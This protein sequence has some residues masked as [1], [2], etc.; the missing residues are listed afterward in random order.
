MSTAL[1]RLQPKYRPVSGEL[2][3]FRLQAAIPNNAARR[4][5]MTANGP[6]A[7]S[8]EAPAFRKP[9][10]IEE[11]MD[12]SYVGMVSDTDCERFAKALR[13]SG[14]TRFQFIDESD[15]PARQRLVDNFS[16]L[17]E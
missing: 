3:G 11:S 7:T 13:A 1:V 6:R 5:V 2:Q 15:D 12:Y 16:I 8:E 10:L 4:M 9:Y 17:S 14:Y